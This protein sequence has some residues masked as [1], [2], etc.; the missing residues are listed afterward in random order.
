VLMMVWS[1]IRRR[2]GRSVALLLAILIAASGFT[3]LTASSEASRLQTVGTVQAH[4]RTVYDILVRPP[5]APSA[6]ETSQGLVAPGLL[7]TSTG[8]ISLDQ[9]HKIQQVPGVDVAAPIAVLGY[10]APHVDMYVDTHQ[11][12]TKT[13]STERVD[14]EWTDPVSRARAANPH[15]MYVSAQ[16]AGAPGM[17]PPENSL[18]GPTTNLTGNPK[19]AGSTVVTAPATVLCAFSPADVRDD[20]GPTSNVLQRI[21]Y[22]FPLLLVAVDPVSEDRLDGL[23]AASGTTGLTAL[24]R[25]PR[26]GNSNGDRVTEVPVLMAT[27]SPVGGSVT[28]TVRRLPAAANTAVTSGMPVTALTALT[29]PVVTRQTFTSDAAYQQMRSKMSTFSD[30]FSAPGLLFQYWSVGAPTLTQMANGDLQAKPVTNDLT[31]LWV[32]GSD[33]SVAPI[34]SDDTQFRPLTLHRQVA[35]RTSGI[36]G[37]PSLTRVG[38]FDP[39]NLTGL[40]DDTARILAG[41]DTVPTTGADATAKAALG[42][43]PVQ[44]STNMG[45]LVSPPPLM[46]TSISAMQPIV[47]GDWQPSAQ[48]SAPVTAVRVRVKDVTGVD[49]ASR[50]RVRLAAQRIQAATGLAVDVTVGSSA[51]T[52]TI[53]EPAGKFGRP[54]LLLRQP[55]VKKGVAVVILKAVDKKSLILFALVLLVCALS[56][57]NSAVASVRARRSELGVLAC[58]GWRRRHL[59]A[60]VLAE[61][62]AVALVAG[63][64]ATVLSVGLGA[65]TGTHVS[66]QRGLLAVPAALAVALVAGMVPAWLA[67]RADPMEAVRAAVHLPRRARAPRTV[68]G[69]G[70][71]NLTRTRARALIAAS[72]LTVSVAAFTLLLAITVAFQGAVVGTILGDAVAVQARGADYAATA[73]TLLLAGLGVANVLYLNIRDRGAEIAT[74][75]ALGWQEKHLARLVIVEGLGIGLMGALPGAAVG[76]GAAAVLA[77]AITAKIVLAAAI[78]VVVG[79]AITAVASAVPVRLLRRLP[80]AVLLTEE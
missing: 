7:S 32:E 18:C 78:A 52:K 27:H 50:A 3:V 40:S 58:L 16:A 74:L 77:G 6:A 72:G 68:T 4:A 69:L 20:N 28:V 79:L 43:R 44:P 21:T 67:A 11:S 56:V 66:W 71:V 23:G 41:W 47:G 37:Y 49:P 25:T 33:F 36:S 48:S 19:P 70:L 35:D 29:G 57:A 24:G 60:I 1:Q 39:S 55:W 14:A 59:F 61:L 10:V 38:D 63:A 34:G 62:T 46:V 76:L 17:P 64:A 65:V 12:G 5:G 54:A 2:G 80:T 13:A 8:G 31:K 22:P 26:S 30:R 73:A 45:A 42:G 51:T 53:S 15:F 75:R 9:W